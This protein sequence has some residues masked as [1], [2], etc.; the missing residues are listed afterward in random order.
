MV[1]DTS[2]DQWLFR[3]DP[4][5][6]RPL[7]IVGHRTNDGIPYLAP[8]IQLL[9]KAKALRPKDEADFARILPALDGK[10]R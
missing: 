10:S 5:I 6:R 8:E 2:D 4:R 7:A 3:R 1:V 9:Y